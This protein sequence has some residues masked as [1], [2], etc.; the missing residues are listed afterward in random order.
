[1]LAVVPSVAGWPSMEEVRN[2]VVPGSRI[3]V[4]G[5]GLTCGGVRFSEAIAA[6]MRGENPEVPVSP[7]A[8][9]PLTT[10][11]LHFLSKFHAY[12]AMVLV[13]IVYLQLLLPKA[14]QPAAR[15]RHLIVGRILV[16]GILWHYFPIAYVLNYF[17]IV[18]DL[19]E[20]KL[21]PP[22][23]E[24]RMQVSYIVPFAITTTVASFLGFWLGRDPWPF[25]RFEKEAG[26]TA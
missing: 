6:N 23:S 17:A 16:Y 4:G 18:I 11:P 19:E 26:Q 2:Y 14:T 9:Y 8:R 22:A 15:S 21:A 10:E 13:L 12:S 25:G 7:V 5:T 24:W 1:M 20:W 3:N